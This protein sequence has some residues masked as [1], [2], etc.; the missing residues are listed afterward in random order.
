MILTVAERINLLQVLP[1]K[2]DYLTLKIL[3]QL[4]LSLGLTE[5]EFKKWDIT[6]E[7]NMIRWQ[8]N[9]EAEI[10]IG[11]VAT[12][13][14]VDTLRELDRNKDLPV[15]LFSVYEKFITTE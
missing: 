2:E 3:N 5:D 10:P 6:Q 8:E 14:V 11:E 12:G 4:K 1:V 15:D 7:D 9:G 13:I